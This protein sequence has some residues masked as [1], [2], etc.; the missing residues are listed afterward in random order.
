MKTVFITLVALLYI[1]AAHADVYQCKEIQAPTMGGGLIKVT[2][3][4]TGKVAQTSAIAQHFDSVYKVNVKIV[5][6]HGPGAVEPMK[7]FNA[8]ATVEDVVYSVSSVKANGVKLMIFLDEPNDAWM[9][10]SDKYGNKRNVKLS[11]GLANPARI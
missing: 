10:L 1:G 5:A 9:E 7:N 2:V 4:E 11:C 8:L 3:T 6:T